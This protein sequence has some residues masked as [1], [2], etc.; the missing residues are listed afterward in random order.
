MLLLMRIRT[1]RARYK[2]RIKADACLG[3]LRLGAFLQRMHVLPRGAMRVC[4]HMC[5]YLRPAL[6]QAQDVGVPRETARR[7]R[8]HGRLGATV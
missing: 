8:R 2:V 6:G 4:L 1:E 7:G 5:A 3:K